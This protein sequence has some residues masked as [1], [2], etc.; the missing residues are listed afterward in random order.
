MDEDRWTTVTESSFDHERR[1]LEAIRAKLPNDEPW[2]AWSNF[3][4][5][6]RYGH[7]REVDLLVI[8]PNG[9]HL[10]ELKDWR[11]RLTVENGDWVRGF[12]NGRRRKL[13][14]NPLHL[15]N[16]KAKELAGLLGE[17]GAPVF[18]ESRLCL[19]HPDLRFEVPEGDRLHTHTIREL[20]EVLGQPP[21]DRQNRI[22]PGRAEKIAAA[23]QRIGIG[24]S[25]ADRM[26]G[27]YKLIEPIGTGPTWT[28]YQAEHTDLGTPAR[29]RIYLSERGADQAARTSVYE[30]AKREAAVLRRFR[31]QGVVRFVDIDSG[32]HPA[33]PALI[34]EYHPDTMRLDEYLAEY[35]ANLDIQDRIELVRQL[36]E[37]I[38]AAHKSR[39]Y[40]RGLAAHAIHVLP[41]ARNSTGRELHG[42][43]RWQHP[44][45]QISD[46]QIATQRSSS[47]LRGLTRYAPTAQQGRN[48]DRGASG[49]G[50]V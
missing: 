29:I 13:H 1:G 16:Q 46:W 44:H 5:T 19:T 27:A 35:G 40:H 9:V 20:V 42:P 28:D 30:A 43:E 10:I 33:G 21:Q 49:H 23:L 31:H 45:L 38:R 4:F 7:I 37:T 12:D 8:A 41:R 48:L 32:G 14:R 22:S 6:E 17:A 50:A 24:R 39:V 26:V 34:F 18:V 3:T 11:G 47:R 2:L 25:E 15:V 36:A